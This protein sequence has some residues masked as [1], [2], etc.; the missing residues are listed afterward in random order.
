MDNVTV[1]EAEIVHFAEEFLDLDVGEI[2]TLLLEE[3]AIIGNEFTIGAF[4][5]DE[6]FIF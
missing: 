3:L 4:G 6:A 5:N 1:G 2:V